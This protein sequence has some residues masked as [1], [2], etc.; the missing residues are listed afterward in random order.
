[1]AIWRRYVVKP[2]RLDY[3]PDVLIVFLDTG[4]LVTGFLA[5]GRRIAADPKHM[6]VVLYRRDNII[7]FPAQK[8]GTTYRPHAVSFCIST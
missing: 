6:S 1:M 2:T 7:H 8:K 3:K 5:R 4:V